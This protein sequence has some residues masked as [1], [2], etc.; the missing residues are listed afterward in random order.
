MGREC[1]FE[2]FLDNINK[3]ILLDTSSRYN[4]RILVPWP[5][6]DKG[7][8]MFS[9]KQSSWM[10]LGVALFAL[11]AFHTV[12][13]DLW[14]HLKTGQ[15]ILA[16]GIPK[17]DIFSFTMAGSPWTTHEWLSEI[18][19]WGFYAHAG[20]FPA[21][22]ITFALVAA[23]TFS[24]VYFTCAGRPIIA[25]PLTL[26]S[27]WTTRFLW[28]SRPQIL[29]I[30]MLA[31][32]M[33]FMENVRQKRFS[34]KA[35]YLLPF[36]IMI[37]V[38]MHSGY[39]MGIGILGVYLVGDALQIFLWKS[40]EGTLGKTA[41]KHLAI[42]VALAA[43][44]TL[45][46][47]NGYR[48]W[49][50]PFGTLGSRMMQSFILEWQP[51]DFHHW[52][53]KPFIICMGLGGMAFMTSHRR[54]SLAE[55]VF[56]AGAMAAGLYSRRHIP[57]FAVVALPII[58][59]AILDSF[60][61]SKWRNLLEGSALPQKIAPVFRI[62]N[63]LLVLVSLVVAG[64]WVH[65]V[66]QKNELSIRDTYPVGA[67]KF[68]KA[69]GLADRHGFSEYTWGGYLL[70]SDLPVFI[71]GRVDMYGDRFFMQYLSIHDLKMNGAKINSIFQHFDVTYAIL[72]PQ[73]SFSGIL[74]SNNQ[75]REVYRDNTAS[76]FLTQP[77][78]PPK[79]PPSV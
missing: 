6:S 58:S 7:K 68:L 26:L 37:W 14:W 76:V 17:T 43:L 2:T 22:V 73:S 65:G 13:P 71:D 34:P 11:G 42:V 62:V 49:L 61:N 21:L 63:M 29:N 18:V 78:L 69:K 70:W 30:L 23:L 77:A 56:Y 40:E 79:S 1:S 55:A 24:L 35:L 67:V 39:L 4:N 64:F 8:I 36:L 72:H 9:I 3:M 75:W 38:N 60:E 50:Y 57:F 16:H 48:I 27:F 31:L 33:W 51:P 5:K 19:M 44:A 46:N 28:G 59:R 15:A 53:Y 52:N 25:L 54:R 10:I 47:P 66:L 45:A 74:R 12:D 20:G 32:V 41:L